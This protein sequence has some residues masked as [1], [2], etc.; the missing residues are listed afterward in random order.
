MRLVNVPMRV[1]LNLPF[2]T[3]L[4]RQLM[5]LF[6]KG[7][8]TGRAYRQPVSYVAD[9]DTLLTP[10][11]GRW[12]L[13]LR[14]GEPVTVRL[15]GTKV[16]LE[17]EFVRDPDEVERLLRLMMA[18][19]R[20]LA[21]FVPFVGADG[22]IDRHSLLPD[23]TNQVHSI[24][25]DEAGN[26]AVEVTIGGTQAKDFGAIMNQGRRYDLP[27][28]FLF[29]VDDEGLIDRI[30]AYWDTANWYTQ[31][32]KV[33]V[34]CDAYQEAGSMGYA[35][36][37]VQAWMP[38]AAGADIAFTSLSSKTTDL[39]RKLRRGEALPTGDFFEG[40]KPAEADRRK[41]GSR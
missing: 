13:N 28:L 31:L 7:R 34:D 11:G 39:R 29:H 40:D 20:R 2:R 21:S 24:R 16:D 17:P 27:H 12:K 36:G 9:G 25:A 15:R 23:L 8:R 18:K 1:V 19:N 10:G 37:S 26:V 3:F 5:L 33:Q 14:E 6:Y 4:S 32:A 22:H 35:G 41:R 30:V 38:D